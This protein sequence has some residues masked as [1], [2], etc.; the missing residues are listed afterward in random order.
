ME[1][2]TAVDE[3]I[4]SRKHSDTAKATIKNYTYRLQRFVEFCERADIDDVG[5]V[6]GRTCEQYKQARL[7]N[8]EVSAYTVEQ[9]LR[10][11]RLFVRWCEGSDLITEGVS[12]KMVIPRIDSESTVRHESLDTERAEEIISYLRKHE[13]AQRTHI[14]FHT[15]WHTGMRLGSMRALDVDDLQKRDSVYIMRVRHRPDRGTPLKLKSAGERNVTVGDEHLVE[16]IDD[17][18]QLNRHDVEDDYG[19]EPF[20]ASRHG[21]LH[22]SSMRSAVYKIVRP[23]YYTAECPHDREI[24]ECEATGHNQYSKCP[25]SMYPH[26]IRS[27]SVTAHLS[28]DIPKEI[29]SER[30]NMSQEIMDKHYDERTEE[31]KRRDRQEYF[32]D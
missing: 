14:L 13:Y 3:Y 23:C 26:A 22:K 15:M 2:Q 8:S 5:D 11:F 25:S 16:A 9:Q 4:E 31:D 21:R 10:T 28:E 30:V 24:S 27:G 32:T 29:L 7:K 1:P 18:L 17:Y 6:T 19:R 12:D 20:I